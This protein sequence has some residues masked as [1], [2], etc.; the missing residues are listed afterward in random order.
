[1]SFTDILRTAFFALRGNWMRSALTSLGVIIGIAA[2][3]VMVSIGQGTQAE[4][5][6]MVSGLG[7]QRLDIGSAGGMGP[8]GARMAQG[9]RWSL[10]E[11]D[12]EAIRNEV[13]EVQ[14]VAGS[15]R[16][17]S[18]VVFAEN[19]ASTQWQ[20]VQADWFAI[21]DWQIVQGQ[22]FDTPDYGGSSKP[23]ILGETVRKTLFGDESGIGQSIR[24]GRVP[25]TVVGILGSKGQG[26]FGQD[27]DDIVVVPLE[28]ARRRLSTA[29]GMPPGAVQ[30]IAVGVDDAKHLD[31]AQAAIEDLL[32]QRHKIQPGADDDFAVRNISQIVATRTAT[33]NLMSKLLG[34]VAGICLIIGGIGIMNIMLVSVTERIREI[35]LRMAVGAGPRDVRLQ[36]LAEAM[37][38]SLIGGIIGIGIGVVGALLVGKFGDLPVQLNAK[39]ILLAATFSICT[40][41]FFGYYPARKASLLDP[42]D[43]LRSQ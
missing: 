28:T 18:Q 17:G 24:L 5:D 14:Y 25:F 1:M 43:A 4:I 10:N 12:V 40:G 22:G 33:T 13:P 27:Q 26:G 15:L 29:Q 9:S 21:N 38:I 32:R 23:V 16:G 42:I 31:A 30:S 11:G 19:N 8:G 36:F 6:K 3:I 41:L 7:S 20:G 2:V 35:G 34:A 39:V 37:L